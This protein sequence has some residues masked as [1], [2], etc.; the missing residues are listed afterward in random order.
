MSE[1]YN[2]IIKV[3]EIISTI[4][5]YLG[6]LTFLVTVFLFLRYF[7]HKYK[8]P[9]LNIFNKN[10]FSDSFLLYKIVI[11]FRKNPNV[12][13]RMFCEYIIVQDYKNKRL[14]T[15]NLRFYY[16]NFLQE[17]VKKDYDS[18]DIDSTFEVIEIY[19]SPYVTR[20]FDF[21]VILKT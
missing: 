5:K 2:Y 13:M 17:Y 7:G 6:A 10:S 4:S 8:K 3:L 1:I 19:S 20:Y 16:K 11:S 15:K 18:I 21:M 12:L 9:I 14:T